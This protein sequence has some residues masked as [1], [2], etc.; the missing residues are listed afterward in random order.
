[1]NSNLEIELSCI[2]KQF[3]I[4]AMGILI[5]IGSLRCLK[6]VKTMDMILGKCKFPNGFLSYFQ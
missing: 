4:L 3:A 5:L 1:M 2:Y 6:E